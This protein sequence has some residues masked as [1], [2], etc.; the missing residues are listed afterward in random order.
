MFNIIA[1]R[2]LLEYCERYKDASSALQLWYH[3]LQKLDIHNF[4]ELKIEFPSASIINDDRVVFNICGN[5]YRLVVRISFEFKAIQIKWFGKHADYN[6]IN[7][8]TIK[9]RKNEI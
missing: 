8:A 3:K 9:F 5:R 1:R 4:N 6:R 2:T 7:V